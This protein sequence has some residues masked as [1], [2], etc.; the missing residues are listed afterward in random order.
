MAAVGAARGGGAGADNN[1]DLRVALENIEKARAQYGI[2][3][4]D[5][6]PS[7]TAQA[8]SNRARGGRPDSTGA[9]TTTSSTRPSWVLPATSWTCGAA[10][11]T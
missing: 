8:Q 1:R 7:I 10:S 2:T 3:R 11:A 6:L 5:L 9:S 4:A